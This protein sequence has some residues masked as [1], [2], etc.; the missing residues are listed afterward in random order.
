MAMIQGYNL[1][2][3]LFYHREHGWVKKESDIV[4]V[5]MTEFF[6][7]AA[8]DIV[9]VDLPFVGDTIEQ[10]QTCGKV[11][12]SKWIGKLIAP[13]S[14]EI[15]EVNQDLENESTLINTNPYDKGWIMTIKPS[16]LEAELANL[17]SKNDEL[18]AWIKSEIERVEKEK[19]K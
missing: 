10:N 6:A 13:V 7:K 1:P 16:N 17:L 15:I 5:G 4:R 18:E 9:Y 8:G 2:E 14:G 12:S 19:K 11:Q 3:G